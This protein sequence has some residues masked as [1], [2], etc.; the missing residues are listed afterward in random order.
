MNSRNTEK[1]PRTLLLLYIEINTCIYNLL[2]RWLTMVDYAR[3]L[4]VPMQARCL[5]CF[6]YAYHYNSSVCECVTCTCTSHYLHLIYLFPYLG[7]NI[8]KSVSQ[9]VRLKVIDK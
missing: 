8:N 3:E 4:M 7:R 5:A 9:V 2:I 1:R 6:L